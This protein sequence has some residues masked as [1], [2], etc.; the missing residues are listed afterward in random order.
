M[1]RRLAGL[2][3]AAGV[4]IT[5]ATVLHAGRTINSFP[6]VENFTTNAWQSDLAWASQG[7]VARHMAGVNWDGGNAARFW[8]PTAGQGYSGLGQ[9]T[10][11]TGI[12]PSRINVRF[13]YQWGSTFLTDDQGAGPKHLLI[14]RSTAVD[15]D[16]FIVQ[17]H[18]FAEGQWD[19]GMGNNIM[20]QYPSPRGV[21]DYS[22]H[23]G[24]PVC[25]EFEST[26]GG[27]MKL[28]ITKRNDSNWN[29]RLLYTVPVNNSNGV[30]HLVDILGAFGGPGARGSAD[31]NAWFQISNLTIS[32][33]Y[34]GPPAGFK[35]T[36]TPP[37]PQAPYNVR[38]V[39]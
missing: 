9:F 24:Q 37:P 33:T 3:L 17:Q 2:A 4:L 30:W 35:S 23:T 36:S 25:F 28:Y 1:L 18:E 12:R 20:P 10:L 39:R 19:V 7:A 15:G 27:S 22:R 29:E 26:I 13:V 8:L 21:W 32:N 31:P 6:F 34:I 16:R 11:A 38:I 5:T 14:N